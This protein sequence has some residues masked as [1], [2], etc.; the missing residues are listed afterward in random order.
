MRGQEKNICLILKAIVFSL[1]LTIVYSQKPTCNSPYVR[2]EIRE[3]IDQ[4]TGT[5]LPEGQDFV[6]AI[7]CMLTNPGTTGGSLWDDF[8]NTHSSAASHAH[9]NQRFLPWRT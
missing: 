8:T 3:L 9:G 2:K 7:N 1:L 5:L 4:A 6:N